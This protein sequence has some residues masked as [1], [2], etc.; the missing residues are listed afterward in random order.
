ML[1]I[2]LICSY[3]LNSNLGLTELDSPLTTLTLAQNSLD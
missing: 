2:L 1:A 3:I